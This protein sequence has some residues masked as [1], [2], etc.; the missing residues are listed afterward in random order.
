MKIKQQTIIDVI[1]TLY[2]MLFL[3]AST[4]KFLEYQQFRVQLGQSPMLTSFAGFVAWFIPSIEVVISALL[5]FTRTR[6]VGLYLAF[7]LMTMFTFYIIAITQFSE[8]VPCSCGGVLQNMG[9][10][11]H[12]IFNTVFVAVAAAG[13][14]LES[15]PAGHP[16][17][18]F[19][20]VPA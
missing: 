11:E 2:I 18:S 5:L 16:S 13:V 1:C 8:Y 9:W 12:L 19:H 15:K 7:G 14:I 3:Y 20:S 10:T 4:T 17:P 6:L